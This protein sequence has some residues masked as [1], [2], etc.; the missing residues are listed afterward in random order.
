MTEPAT[1]QRSAQAPTTTGPPVTGSTKWLILGILAFAGFW[2][3][4]AV[5][6]WTSRGHYIENAALRGAD[7]VDAAL[8]VEADSA[9]NAITETSL[10]IVSFLVVAMALLRR[11]VD[12]A[13]AASAI[14]VGSSLITQ[15][16]K[17]FVL[18]R[19]ELIE[20]TGPY[21]INSFP[22][23]HTT[24]AMS[25]LFALLIVVPF[26]WRGVAM[27]FGAFFAVAIGA[28]TLT[29]KWHRFSDTLGADLVA[30]GIACLVTIALVQRGSLVRVTAGRY[31]L[32]VLFVVAPL[33]LSTVVSLGLGMLLL[34]LSELPT[35]PDEVLDY[36]MYLALHGLAAGA[37]GLTALAFWWSW[38]RIDVGSPASPAS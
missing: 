28:H 1:A 13:I 36:N 30:F 25:V 19:P 24:I 5:F 14:I 17:R 7:Q 3:T 8:V 6:V 21:T 27:F 26:K 20:V 11:R 22:S 2:V 29:S 35:A 15:V 37:S 23:G 38:R 32:R 4:Y 10:A 9:L 16:L 12:L 18:P 31:P 33:A 34:L